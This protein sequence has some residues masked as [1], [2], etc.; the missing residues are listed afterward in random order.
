[1]YYKIFVP[2]EMLNKC[3]PSTYNTYY[4]YF[5]LLNIQT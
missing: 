4:Y 3:A 2:Y 5:M 1:M